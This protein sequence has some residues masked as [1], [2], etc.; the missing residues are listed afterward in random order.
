MC[1][2]TWV[3]IEDY[4]QSMTPL[5]SGLETLRRQPQQQQ[6]Q[7]QQPQG[8]NDHA[9]GKEDQHK[10]CNRRELGTVRSVL[11]WSPFSLFFFSS[12]SYSPVDISL[13][14]I[15]RP[16]LSSYTPTHVYARTGTCV[17]C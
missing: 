7:Q 14:Y 12:S 8:S 9:H 6:P 17:R 15:L 11:F 16:T 13:L 2:L 4:E 5:P 1:R 3:G 10:H